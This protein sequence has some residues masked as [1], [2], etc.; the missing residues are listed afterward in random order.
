MKIIILHGEDIHKSYERLIKFIDAAKKRNW[1]ILQDNVSVT[2]SLFGTESLIVIRDLKLFNQK[3]IKTLNKISGTLV[4]YSEGNLPAAFLKIFPK[5]AKVERYDVPK[6]IWNFLDNITAKSLHEVIKTEPTEF[7][8]ALISKRIRDLYWIKTGAKNL[9]YQEWQISKMQKQ[10][11][12]YSL[13]QLKETLDS[14]SEIDI[15]SKTGK[16]DLVSSL[17]LLIVKHLE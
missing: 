7:V 15:E 17:D 5:D 3:L 1:E 6:I 14:L 10:T 13:D 11:N 9:P 12:K 2:P 16:G 4:I 8:F